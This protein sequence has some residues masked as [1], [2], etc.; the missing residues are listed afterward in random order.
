MSQVKIGWSKRELSTLEPVTIPGQMYMRI[1]EGVHD[2][3]Y[4]TA[5]CVD[6]GAGQ[7]CVIFCTCDVVVLRGGVIELT[8][9]KV[10]ALR[11]EIPV[12]N[13]IMGAT[14]THA[15]GGATDT[16]EK[17]PDGTPIYPGAKYREF[18]TDQCAEAIVEAWDTRAEGGIGYGYGYAVVAHSRRVIYLQ[19]QG[20]INPNAVAPNGHGVMYG[21][22]KKDDFSHYEA[23][24]DHFLNLMFT[25]DARQKLTGIV[26]NV[27]CPSQLSE[28]FRKLSADYW[29]EVRQ[30]VA[31][32]Y[33][34]NVFVLP[35]CA[36]AG[37]LS[38]RTLHY[39]DAQV[40]RMTLK[41][42]LPYDY[43]K[44]SE[45]GLDEY[46]KVMGERYDIAERIMNGIR[47]VYSWAKKDVQTEV[48]V[49]HQ[50]K[51]LK[52]ARRMISDAEKIE[53]EEN[54][55]KMRAAIPDPATCTKEEFRVAMSRY[56]SIKGRN[57]RAI[58][59]YHNQNE[60]PTLDT[61]IHVV[62]IGDIA[63]AT[64]RFELFMDFMHRIQARSPF[65]QTFVIQLAGVEG[66][67]YLSTQR[68]T[69][70]K[71]YSASLFCNQVSYEGGQ[72]LVENTLD[73]LADMY[74][75]NEG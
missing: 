72:Q 73:I 43:K 57:E 68:G 20:K 74:E 17:S 34:E 13:I 55:E 35:Q 7:D 33:G 15:G 52:L 26:V 38:P 69:N 46:N 62:Q 9:K 63:F 65:I 67:S 28:H 48:A 42:G 64:N 16:P 31:K 14:H 60:N 61:A 32:E 58:E 18:F 44:T 39:K 70:N 75:K 50:F 71:G 11:P 40:R 25:F 56:N 22:T 59:R 66:G 2:P 45:H 36:A 8:R 53:C 3:L 1:S 29:N 30:L 41:Y 49:R 47:D 27:P 6:G 21:N 5:L 12:M 19:D 23:G 24:A 37:D 4:A 51:E 54:F 10:A